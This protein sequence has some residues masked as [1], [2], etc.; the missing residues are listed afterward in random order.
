MVSRYTGKAGEYMWH[1]E[2]ERLERSKVRP[3]ELQS[4]EAVGNPGLVLLGVG[5]GIVVA[6]IVFSLL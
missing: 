4:R 2:M 6:S 5:I 1:K 3:W